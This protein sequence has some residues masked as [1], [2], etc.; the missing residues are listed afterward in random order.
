MPWNHFRTRTDD[1]GVIFE[2]SRKVRPESHR[3]NNS[4]PPTWLSRCG[5]AHG[6]GELNRPL[7]PAVARAA[8]GH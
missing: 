8:A 3:V 6:L 2:Y 5:R 7:D 1:P 4:D